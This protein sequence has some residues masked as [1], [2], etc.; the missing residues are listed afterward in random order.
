MSYQFLTTR[1]EGAV[2]YLTLNRPE[3]RN[4]LNDVMIAELT[5]WAAS[6]REAA[7]RGS[8]RAVVL[9][10]AGKSFCAGADIA[11]MAKTVAYTT[12]ENLQDAVATARMFG[13]ID[14]LPVPVIGLIHAGA[15]GGGA[16]LAAVCDIAVADEQAVFGFPEVRL[17][18]IP[19]VISPF[20]LAKIGRSAARELFLTG[21]RFPATRAQEIGLVHVVVP[22]DELDRT[23]ARYVEDVLASAPQAFAVAKALIAEIWGRPA[24]DADPITASAIAHR[25]VSVEGQEGLG[26]FLG[27]HTPSWAE[28]ALPTDRPTTR[29]SSGPRG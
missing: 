1:Q 28:D 16:G 25:R 6:V 12:E 21:R 2:E 17:G 10:G 9:A 14:S 19:A 7:A 15:I 27:K 11:W 22:A 29:P 24:A 4:A 20:V 3:V 23:V 18:I 13:A 5:G 26:A 8:V